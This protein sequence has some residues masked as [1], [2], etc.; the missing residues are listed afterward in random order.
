MSTTE[1][2]TIRPKKTT[3]TKQ[4]LPNFVGISEARAGSKHLSMT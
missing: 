3:I 2:V 4:Q 1:I